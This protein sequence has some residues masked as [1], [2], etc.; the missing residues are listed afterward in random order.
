MIFWTLKWS[1]YYSIC[2][3]SY[4]SHRNV[5]WSNNEAIWWKRVT[6]FI[7]L[8]FHSFFP[9]FLFFRMANNGVC[10]FGKFF[11]FLSF[12]EKGICRKHIHAIF[13][14]SR[15]KE[16]LISVLF[17][18]LNSASYI[19][20]NVSLHISWNMRTLKANSL[21]REGGRSWERAIQ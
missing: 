3:S 21:M 9:F 16:S 19:Y 15:G 6:S 4:Q 1:I 2:R 13:D 14:R 11:S 12:Q 17:M 7:C 8:A 20:E 10:L 5:Y 18:C